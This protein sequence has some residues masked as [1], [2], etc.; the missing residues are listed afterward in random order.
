MKHNNNIYLNN[1]RI[2]TFIKDLYN[3]NRSLTGDGNYKTFKYLKSNILPNLKLKKV[4]SG[5]KVFDWNIPPEWNVKDA[6]VKNKYGKKIIDFKKNN[7]H[8]M[9]YSIPYKGKI[10]KKNL[11]NHIHT[12][13]N[14]INWIPYRT[15]YYKRTWGFCVQHK[16]LNSNDFVGPFEVFIDTN[17]NNKGNL[18][19]AEY[20]KKGRSR[21]EIIISTYCC[22]PALANDNLSGLIT[23]PLLFN[24][25][26]K[27]N[28]KFSYRL[29]IAPETI[30][31]INF[32]SQNIGNK[33][34]GGM[35]LSCTGGPGQ[36]SIK[37]SYNKE[38]WINS[39]AHETLKKFTKN[40]YIEYP[41]EPNGSDERQFSSPGFRINTPSIHKSKYYEYDEYHTSADNLNFISDK[42]II[43][44]LKVHIKWIQSIE[45]LEVPIRRNNYCEYNLGKRK[46][47]PQ[48]GGSMNQ[49]A[50]K[51]NFTKDM[52]DS[53]DWI[54]HLAD[55]SNTN[56]D[57]A[58]KSGINL[59]IIN[60]AISLF[61][62]KKLIEDL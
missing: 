8:L 54:M 47:Y 43:D 52:Y 33:I 62:D 18:M 55:G 58:K 1:S 13:P 19:W 3:I 35:I 41:F 50:F 11:L 6:Y 15:S 28:T 29:L 24:Y 17:I 2:K 39:C 57:I 22:H 14:H 38:H 37:N 5:T 12:L 48:I 9:S 4:N 45:S 53:F 30:G 46:L 61:K 59:R 7:L 10:S 36:F 27:L 23:A 40:K 51:E 31:A 32:L 60:Q 56:T 20:L 16:L 49:S 42:S 44:S 34:L 25:I 26:Q 21:K